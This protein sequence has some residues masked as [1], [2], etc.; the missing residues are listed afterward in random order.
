[1]DNYIIFGALEAFGGSLIYKLC[2]DIIIKKRKINIRKY[3]NFGL[4]V[5]ASI[6]LLRAYLNKSILDYFYYDFLLK[7]HDLL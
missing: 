5:G 4:L 1:M 3:L 2:D 7:D 6:G